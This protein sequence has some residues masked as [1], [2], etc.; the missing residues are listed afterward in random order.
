MPSGTLARYLTA[1]G[2]FSVQF[3]AKW[4][5][6]RCWQ[7]WSESPIGKHQNH[8]GNY[9]PFDWPL[10]SWLV[11]TFPGPSSACQLTDDL[12]KIRYM[13]VTE[14]K[15]RLDN[16]KR[17]HLKWY[18]LVD[19]TI[20]CAPTKD[21]VSR[22]NSVHIGLRINGENATLIKVRQ[23]PKDDARFRS[24]VLVVPGNWSHLI[25]ISI[26][27]TGNVTVKNFPNVTFRVDLVSPHLKEGLFIF[28]WL[29]KHVIVVEIA[30]RRRVYVTP[31]S[32][33]KFVPLVGP[34]DVAGGTYKKY[35]K[36]YDWLSSVDL[37]YLFGRDDQKIGRTLS[38]DRRWFAEAPHGKGFDGQVSARLSALTM[39]IVACSW[40]RV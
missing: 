13:P 16:Y 3:V 34:A 19:I 39:R 20:L 29:E 4:S 28:L 38:L 24:Q 30:K 5:P 15:V 26:G 1:M 33:W 27:T 37:Y 10:G 17:R 32:I 22:V 23:L 25:A 8:Q 21:R 6:Y 7:S 31:S 36:K 18:L 35:L 40:L 11:D 14:K 12:R 9:K 2:S